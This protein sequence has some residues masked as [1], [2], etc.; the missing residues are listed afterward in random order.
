MKEKWVAPRTVIEEFAPNEYVAVCWGVGCLVETANAY[1]MSHYST[2]GWQTWY[3]LDCKHAEG[4]CG[5]N[6]NQVIRDWNNDGIGDQ[7]V[8]IGTDG[9]GNLACTIYSDSEYTHM[10]AVKDVKPGMQIYWTTS[11]GNKT[12]HHVGNVYPT[13]S[14]RP[15]A[16]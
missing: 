8:E 15:N 3:D 10:I 16:S 14:K 4:H 13:N 1:E 11:A 12:W 9:L 2:N 7:M 6:S 5:T